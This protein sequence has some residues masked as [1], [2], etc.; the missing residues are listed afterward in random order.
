MDKNSFGPAFT[1]SGYPIQLVELNRLIRTELHD[2]HVA[3]VLADKI[4]QDMIWTHPIVVERNALIILDGHHRYDAARKLGLGYIPCIT[5][6]Y[7]DSRLRLECWRSD[8]QVSK[9]DVL[10]VKHTG[11]LFPYKTTKHILSPAIG[12]CAVPLAQLTLSATQLVGCV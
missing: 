9:V 4:R 12:Q 6:D 7:E 11:K 2:Q 1:T 10:R 8:E 5:I 3:N